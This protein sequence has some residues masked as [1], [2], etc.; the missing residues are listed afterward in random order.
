MLDLQA[1]VGLHEEELVR[2]LV[3]H[4]EL[5]G[6]RAGVA[7]TA[8][9]VA[10]CLAHP[11]AGRGV[12]ERR[13]RLLDD[14]LVP[15]LQRALALAEVDGRAVL[16]GEHLHLDVPRRSQVAL[17][18]ESVVAERGRGDPAGRGDTVGEV[19]LTLDHGHPLAATAGG[20]T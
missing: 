12:E 8:G 20:R 15:A 9:D 7:H 19:A 1:G 5:D 11:S 3:G 4:Q 17:E 6:A 10:R 2:S 18:K 14:L 13:R 16:I